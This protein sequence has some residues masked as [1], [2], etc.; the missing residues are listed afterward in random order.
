MSKY[1][2]FVFLTVIIG[3]FATPVAQRGNNKSLKIPFR[4]VRIPLKA[5]ATGTV[6]RRTLWPRMFSEG[7]AEG[8]DNNNPSGSISS[9]M[10]MRVGY[11]RIALH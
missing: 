5:N 6:V 7:T 2:L 1:S 10:Q 3:N 4:S 9:T 8:D 11:V